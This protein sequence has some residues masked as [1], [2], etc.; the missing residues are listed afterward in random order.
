[1]AEAGRREVGGEIA[2]DPLAQPDEDAR[3]E[4]GR[5]LGE[6]PG[7]RVARPGAECLD[8]AGRPS[9]LPT[10]VSVRERRIPAIPFR[11]RYDP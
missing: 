2:V 4:P 7:E 5:G 10:S 11:A 8:R 6:R 9:P 3:G 1:M